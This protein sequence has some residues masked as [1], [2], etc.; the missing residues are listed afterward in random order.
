[1]RQEYSL[2]TL[3]EILNQYPSLGEIK[4]HK[5]FT[6]GFEN[7]NYYVE[8]TTGK[9]VIKIFEGIGVSKE[10]ILFEIEVMVFCSQHGLKIPALYKTKHGSHF[11][12]LNNGEKI[13]IVME[14]IEGEN[15]FKQQLSDSIAAAIGQEAGKMDAALQYFKDGAK[16]RQNY[17]W[18]MKNFLQLE[19]SLNLLPAA[20]DKNMVQNIFNKFRKILPTFS[21]LPKGLIHNDIAAHNLLAQGNELKAIIDFSD[22]AFSPYIQNIAVFLAQSVFSYSWQ[23]HQTKIFLR[24]YQKHRPLGKE[25]MEILYDLILARYAAII[26]EFN[27]WN[28]EYG[29]DKQRTE[30]VNDHYSFLQKFLNIPRDEFA[31][32]LR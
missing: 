20:F 11:T 26:V 9:F 8:T 2:S 10:N 28:V 21:S 12:A 25:E 13:V 24:E 30:Y 15:L 14:F 27:R 19:A 29:E 22:M 16:T 4:E 31:N 32:L 18:D 3:Q 6:S 23:P 1:M 5:L 7:S 17:Q